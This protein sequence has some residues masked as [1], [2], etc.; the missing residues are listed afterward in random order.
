M[1]SVPLVGAPGRFDDDLSPEHAGGNVNRRDLRHRDAFF[2]AAEQ[3]RLDAGHPL[4][5]DDQSCREEEVALRP[6]AGG[7]GLGRRRIHGAVGH[8][9]IYELGQ[10][11]PSQETRCLLRWE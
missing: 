5:A 1:G 4:R 11:N 7:E 9:H 8:S 6:P 10:S 2:V 3:P